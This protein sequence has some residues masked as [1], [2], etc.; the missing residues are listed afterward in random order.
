MPT[1]LL[2][3]AL[4]VSVDSRRL[5]HRNTLLR[6]AYFGLEPSLPPVEGLMLRPEAQR[7]VRR[8]HAFKDHARR[9]HLHHPASCIVNDP[10]DPVCDSIAL[11]AV[12]E[13][14]AV[15]PESAIA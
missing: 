5:Y 13:H 3:G 2:G 15:N 4:H 14:R 7:F 11:T 9:L 1:S 12:L 8:I 6:H 10:F